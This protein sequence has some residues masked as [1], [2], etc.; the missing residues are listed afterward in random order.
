MILA[1]L[2]LEKYRNLIDQK[3]TFS[4]QANIISGKNGQG[5]SNL[6][7]AIYQLSS[8][9]SFRTPLTREVIQWGSSGFRLAGEVKTN[10]Q[11]FCLEIQQTESSKKLQ[12]NQ[13]KRDIFD[14]LGY[15][16]VHIFSA[17]QLER[18]RSEPEQRRKFI[19]RGLYWLQPSHLRRMADYSRLLKQKNSFLRSADWIYNN[20]F[21]NLLDAW[22]ERIAELGAEIIASRCEYVEKVRQKLFSQTGTFVPEK[23]NIHYRPCND[24]SISNESENIRLQL[25]SKINS[26]RN[27][28]IRLKRSLVGPHRDDLEIRVDGKEMQRYSSAGQQKSAFLAFHLAQM[29]LHYNLYRE[30]PI[31]LID[32]IDSELDDERMNRVIELLGR[33]TQIFVTSTRPENIR[34]DAHGITAKRFTVE[35]GAVTQTQV[36]QI[37]YSC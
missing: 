7:E 16:N 28:E 13:N 6:L 4:D 20:K 18:F 1:R 33:K 15:L 32:D 34:L 23:V 21:G 17:S 36:S 24:I 30:H 10:Q 9:R 2:A 12:I 26:C 3:L 19:D 35:A 14:Y 11:T 22:D 37:H 8:T 27:Q 31:F 5:K 25:V 29:E